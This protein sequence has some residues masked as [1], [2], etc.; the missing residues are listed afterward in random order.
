M[1]Y[2]AITKVSTLSVMSHKIVTIIAIL[3]SVIISTSF[4][5]SNQ[6]F[7]TCLIQESNVIIRLV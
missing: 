4:T 1:Y 3:A 2:N 5:I 6:L 7:A